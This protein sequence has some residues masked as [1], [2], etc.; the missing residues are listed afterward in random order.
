MSANLA[1][2]H[3]RADAE[4]ERQARQELTEK[5]LDGKEVGRCNL[6]DLIDSELNSERS[7]ILI[8]DFEAL[9][10]MDSGRDYKADEIRDGLIER[11]L[12]S[13][14]CQDIVQDLMTTIEEERE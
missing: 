3:E 14:R 1:K 9:L 6:R 8:T 4:L 2:M 12:E 7:R 13:P 10:L 11:Y 5:L